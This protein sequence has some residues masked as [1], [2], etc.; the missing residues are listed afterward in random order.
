[1]LFIVRAGIGKA[2]AGRDEYRSF[3]DLGKTFF[4]NTVVQGKK[5]SWIRLTEQS[6]YTL[7]KWSC[8]GKRLTFGAPGRMIGARPRIG[9]QP[10]SPELYGFEQNQKNRAKGE[11][12]GL[13]PGI[14]YGLQA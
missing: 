8:Q 3:A 4:G 6:L 10:A 7:D 9:F 12:K 1:M 11:R 5:V 13:V 14:E 2:K